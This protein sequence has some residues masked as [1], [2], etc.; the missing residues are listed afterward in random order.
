MDVSPK[1]H[2]SSIFYDPRVTVVF[3]I[4]SSWAIFYMPITYVGEQSLPCD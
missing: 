1:I 4:H 3:G 2:L